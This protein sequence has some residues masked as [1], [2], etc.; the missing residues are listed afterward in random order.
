MT[1]E[2]RPAARRRLGPRSHGTVEAEADVDAD[3]VGPNV[4][5][6]VW[7]GD[8]VAGPDAGTPGPEF[9]G[10]AAEPQAATSIRTMEA[11]RTLLDRMIR[12]SGW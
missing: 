8:S 10:D 12:S 11:V 1:F 5:G 9:G 6:L 4:G 2:R 7:L 3:V